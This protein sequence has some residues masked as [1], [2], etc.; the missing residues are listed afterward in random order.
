MI[1]LDLILSGSGIA[2]IPAGSNRPRRIKHFARNGPKFN[3]SLQKISGYLTG[4]RRGLRQTEEL[5]H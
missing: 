4:C 5:L 3:P 1:N 2:R